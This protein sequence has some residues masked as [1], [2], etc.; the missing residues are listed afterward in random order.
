MHVLIVQ[1]ERLAR[2]RTFDADE[3][4]REMSAIMAEQTELEKE[5]EARTAQHPFDAEQDN[6][7]RM[8]SKDDG[9]GG[10]GSRDVQQR[11]RARAPQKI[12][13]ESAEDLEVEVAGASFLVDRESGIVFELLEEGDDPPEV[14]SWDEAARKIV[15][16]AQP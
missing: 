5:Q 15:F 10:G 7:R 1:M 4:E 14:G 2:L 9:G 11:D 13:E 6:S 12:V 3:E 16:S 8:P